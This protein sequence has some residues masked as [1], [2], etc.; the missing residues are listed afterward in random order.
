MGEPSRVR[1]GVHTGQA[2][3]GGDSYVGLDVHLAA[4]IGAA[5]HGGQ[6]LL[7]AATK[8]LVEADGIDAIALRDLGPHRLKDFDT[9]IRRGRSLSPGFG[10]SFRHSVPS[11]PRWTCPPS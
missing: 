5:A 4:R 9:P 2:R 3:R 8:S 11:R 10:R 6:L 1:M 7:S